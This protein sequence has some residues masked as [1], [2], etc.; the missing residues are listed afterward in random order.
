MKRIIIILIGILFVLTTFGQSHIFKNNKETTYK[1][2]K[3]GRWI[4]CTSE[5]EIKTKPDDIGTYELSF[6]RY[7]KSHPET[8]LRVIFVK[9]LRGTFNYMGF[10]GIDKVEITTGVKLSQMS[11]GKPGMISIFLH[12]ATI[13]F[14]LSNY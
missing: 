5:V 4:L 8:V 14:K 11:K 2:G 9:E 3:W 7:G 10:I 1:N 13:G 12:D 6:Y